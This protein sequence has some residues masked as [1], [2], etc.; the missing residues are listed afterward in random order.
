MQK[1]RRDRF[2]DLL[3]IVES[4][5]D[6]AEISAKVKAYHASS[7]LLAS[8][9]EG[10]ILA[11]FYCFPGKARRSATYQHWQTR[12]GNILHWDFSQL[13]ALANELKWIPPRVRVGNSKYSISQVLNELRKTRNMIHPGNYLRTWHGKKVGSKEFK[14]TTALFQACVRELDNTLEG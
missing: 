3:R 4:Y 6:Q 8:A 10:S 9:I 12:K 13:I 2:G 11:M 7:I 1:P 14:H 5:K